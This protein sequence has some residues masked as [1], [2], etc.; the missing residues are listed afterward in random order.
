MEKKEEEANY[1]DGKK[2]FVVGCSLT[3]V[4]KIVVVEP[5]FVVVAE[6]FEFAYS[7][8]SCSAWL[9]TCSS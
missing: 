4:E 8:R 7:I 3:V 1:L 2:H 9:R 6:P 5:S